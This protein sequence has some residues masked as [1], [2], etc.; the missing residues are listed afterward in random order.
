MSDREIVNHVL[1][2]NGGGPQGE[3]CVDALLR[4]MAGRGIEGMDPDKAAGLAQALWLA[5]EE[6]DAAIKELIDHLKE[7]RYF[8]TA[9]DEIKPDKDSSSWNCDVSSGEMDRVVHAMRRLTMAR[10]RARPAR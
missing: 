7:L 1:T 8:I 4:A 5:E 3:R 6:A 9:T 10:R 2:E